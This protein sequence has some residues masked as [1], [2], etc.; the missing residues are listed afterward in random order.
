[1]PL[2]AALTQLQQMQTRKRSGHVTQYIGLVIEAVCLQV[3]IGEICEVFPINRDDSVKAEVVGFK[4]N[5]VLLMPYRKIR[6]VT[7]GS[8][9]VA[10]GEMASTYVG[11]D[12][13]GRVVDAFVQPLDEGEPLTGSEYYPLYQEPINPLDRAKI[14]EPVETGIRAIDH[15]IT[16]GKGQ[17]VGIFAGSG[18]GKSSLLTS[19]C[20]NINTDINVIALIGERGREVQE[21]VEQTLKDERMKNTVVIVATAEQPPLV[22]AHAVYSSIAIAEYFS[23][24]GKQVLFTMDSV[25]RFA[26]ALREIGLAIGEPPTV[27][28]YTTSVF[29]QIPTIV[30]RCGNFKHGGSITALFNVLVEGDDFNDPIVDTI[31]AIVDGHIVLTRELAERGHFPAINVL[32]STSRLFN[33]L[34]VDEQIQAVK[35]IRTTLSQYQDSKELI[36]IGAVSQD[37]NDQLSTLIARYQEVEKFLCQKMTEKGEFSKDKVL[38][39]QLAVIAVNDSV[40]KGINKHVS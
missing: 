34:N 25:T 6:G 31:R 18:V 1:M 35:Q 2:S 20:Q 33:T 11:D 22:R 23:N 38:L 5:R 10:T 40:I 28:G 37:E 19:I 16:L 27:K 13:L 8:E 26:M 29:S 9:V 24:Q 3:F 21:F 12:L 14:A 36:E 17:R 15:F 39:Q 30:E 4:E 7:M 32:K